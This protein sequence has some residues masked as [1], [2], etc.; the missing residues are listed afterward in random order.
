MARYSVGAYTYEDDSPDTMIYDGAH[1]HPVELGVRTRVAG[2][3]G[4]R[5]GRRPRREG[6]HRGSRPVCDAQAV[7]VLSGIP[8]TTCAP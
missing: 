3:R 7:R 2:A 6:R 1:R 5:E 4:H 8:S